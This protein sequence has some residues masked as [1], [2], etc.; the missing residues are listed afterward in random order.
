MSFFFFLIQEA[1][2]NINELC[3]DASIKFRGHLRGSQR[4]VGS[5]KLPGTQDPDN[6]AKEAIILSRPSSGLKSESAMENNKSMTHLIGVFPVPVASPT[7]GR[8]RWCVRVCEPLEFIAGSRGE[9]NQG[10]NIYLIGF[11]VFVFLFH[12]WTSW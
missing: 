9:Q 1:L 6:E 10:G 2:N 3:T 7:R 8:L 12:S 11:W 5:I 4:L